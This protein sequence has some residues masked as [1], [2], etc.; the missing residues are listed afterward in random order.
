MDETYLGTLCTHLAEHEPRPG[1]WAKRLAGRPQRGDLSSLSFF[2][3]TPQEVLSMARDAGLPLPGLDDV[4]DVDLTQWAVEANALTAV[5]T[6]YARLTPV[7]P[8]PH[9]AGGQDL[10][11][12]LGSIHPDDLGQAVVD[13][14]LGQI[15]ACQHGMFS[16]ILHY[17]P[18]ARTG[19]VDLRTVA[20][21]A[22][23]VPGRPAELYTNPTGHY[24]HRLQ[25]GTG[26][27]WPALDFAQSFY[28]ARPAL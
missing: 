5:L 24:E 1:Q 18:Q 20:A 14:M 3:L 12:A 28:G 2:S 16:R 15:S 6:T 25:H 9:E 26:R 4:D 10:G 7:Y 22:Y 11:H 21:L 17:L 19:P 27:W 8:H 23:T 13:M